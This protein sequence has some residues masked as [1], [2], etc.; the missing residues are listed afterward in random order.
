MKDEKKKFEDYPKPS[1]ADEQFRH[2]DEFISQKPNEK[3]HVS[4]V[5]GR[6]NEGKPQVKKD[7][8]GE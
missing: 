5:P 3:S 7:E 8:R 2:Q 1:Q 6:E 4:D